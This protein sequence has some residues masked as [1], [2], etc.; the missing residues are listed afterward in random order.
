[1]FLYTNESQRLTIDLHGDVSIG[2]ITLVSSLHVAGNTTS[3]FTTGNHIGQD[4]TNVNNT[5]INIVAAPTPNTCRIEPKT[6]WSNPSTYNGRMLYTSNNNQMY[7]YALAGYI[8]W[9]TVHKLY[10]LWLL[11]LLLLQGIG[12][13]YV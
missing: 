12:L 10:V 3:A 4:P 1:M 7:F 2:T 5:T 11:V 13:N 9:S 8:F 6:I